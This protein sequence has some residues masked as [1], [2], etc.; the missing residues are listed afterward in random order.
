VKEKQA[1][2]ITVNG[3][4]YKIA[5]NSTVIDLLNEL[6]LAQE[7]VAIEYN[8]SVLPRASWAVIELSE[9]DRLEIV[10]FVGGG[11]IC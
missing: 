9:G 11:Q 8:L 2:E 6:R 5:E 1:I 10:H 7:K 4:P 3:D